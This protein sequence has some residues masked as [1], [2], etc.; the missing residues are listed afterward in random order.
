MKLSHFL[1]GAGAL[2]LAGLVVAG[3]LTQSTLTGFDRAGEAPITLADHGAA[4]E[5]RGLDGWINSAPIALAETRGRVVLLDFWTYDC[6]NCIRT[7]PQLRRWHERFA[8]RG[9]VIIGVHSPEFA[10]EREPR[11]VAAAVRRLCLSYPVALDTRHTVW[12]DY[13]IQF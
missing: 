10:Y 9:L 7:I 1:I 13:E 5:F 6:V 11:R 2:L 8:A 3:G 4:P 12:S